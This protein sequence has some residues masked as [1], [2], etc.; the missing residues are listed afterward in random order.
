M[1]IKKINL[2]SLTKF[3]SKN[4]KESSVEMQIRTMHIE[5]AIFKEGILWFKHKM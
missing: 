5:S 1:K 2:N 3:S 4:K